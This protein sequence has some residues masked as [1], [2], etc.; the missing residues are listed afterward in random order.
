MKIGDMVRYNGREVS[1]G[2]EEKSWVGIIVDFEKGGG[3]CAIVFLNKDFPDE[4]EY[5]SQLEVISE[6]A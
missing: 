2:P 3:T 6:K 1:I 4:R 5:T